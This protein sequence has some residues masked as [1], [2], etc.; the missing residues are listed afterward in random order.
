[1][2]LPFSSTDLDSSLDPKTFAYETGMI[3]FGLSWM[4]KAG[5]WQVVIRAA[6]KDSSRWYA[7]LTG[8]ADP[9]EGT[10]LL[11]DILYTRHGRDLWRKDG[12]A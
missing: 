6:K 5:G 1:M 2:N 3:L 8:Q 12:F 4:L 7:M 11:L 10:K 9:I